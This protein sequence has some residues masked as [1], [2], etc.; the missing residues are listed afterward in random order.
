MFN[1]SIFGN[2]RDNIK[3]E[4]SKAEVI[5]VSDLYID[6]YLGGAEITS[7][8]L[9]KKI[10]SE[11]RKIAKIKS[12]ELD[13]ELIEAGIDGHWVFFN[14]AGMDLNL[15]PSLVANIKYSIVEYDYKFCKY[16]STEKH[17]EN[18]QK[19]CD[20]HE[21]M[22]G[23]LI[24]AF[25]YGAE[26]LMWMSDSQRNFYYER[27]P[28]LKEKNNYTIS[29]AFSRETINKLSKNRKNKK[30]NSKAL[31]VGSDSW[32]KG[33]QDSVKYC[34]DK[35]FDFDKIKNVPHNELIKK[36]GEYEHFVFMPKGKDTCPR[37][38]IE[39]KISGMHIHTNLNC[40]HTTENWWTTPEEVEAYISAYPQEKFFSV[41]TETI[42]KIETISGYTTTK[43]CI[44]QQYPYKEAIKSMLGFCDQVVV[45]DGGSTDGTWESLIELSKSDDRIIIEQNKRDWSHPRFAVF[46]GLQ[47]AY[48]RSL[49]TSD[50]CW[51]ID[52]DE[53]VHEKDY[54]K[55]KNL[56]KRIPKSVHLIALPVIEYWGSS[57]KVRIDVNPWK[58]RL[59]RN[60]K[61][62]THG[63]PKQFRRE[64]EEG[65]LYAYP[66]TDGCDYIDTNNFEIIPCMNFYSSDIH[67]EK[68]RALSGD[69]E[70]LERYENWFNNAIENLPGVHHYSW[71]DLERKIKTY[72]NYWSKHWQSLYNIEQQDTIENNMFFDKKWE[73]VSEEDI[74]VLAKKLKEKMGGWVFHKKINF[75]KTTPHVFI[76]RS[77]PEIMNDTK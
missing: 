43:D 4:V 57:E 17:Y 38:L 73:E 55:I 46:D 49:C 63:I 67:E 32:I 39:A 23:K 41:I 33:V 72:K 24:S 22:Q 54:Q 26:N 52:S 9:I 13:L 35:K 53:V 74:K 47:K 68:L 60:H 27:F 59:S 75:E 7:E 64:D 34:T 40:Q 65:N 15:I 50:W 21:S 5:F 56:I 3:D 25:M 61:H 29:S 8:N 16:R 10:S 14:Y 30:R 6:D 70:S 31:I 48:A 28:F 76:E 51:Q 20:C 19:E 42:E 77:E 71:M 11:G 36:M 44:T 66:G 1:T 69:L 2:N 62:I 12:R 45:V 37:I 18:E 58:W